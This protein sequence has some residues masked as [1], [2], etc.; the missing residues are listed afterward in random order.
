MGMAC[1]M[2][3]GVVLADV[4][5]AEPRNGPR[6][7]L[8]K[9]IRDGLVAS[10]A[11]MAGGNCGTPANFASIPFSDSDTTTGAT[12]IISTLPA[13]CSDWTQVAG[14]QKVYSFTAG[15]G[16]NLSFTVTPSNQSYDTSIYLVSSCSSGA[17]CIAGADYYYNYYDPGH[18]E[19][20]S[21]SSLT[22]GTTYYLHVDS[23]YSSSG[24]GGAYSSGPYALSV[25]GTLPVQLQEFQID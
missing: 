19:S 7:Q 10:P 9:Q 3:L 1:V 17:S 12:D 13:G 25:T 8:A 18:A 5:N 4:A 16:A 6:A 15:S 22:A 23:Y 11:P 21:V 2:A 14:P 20:F 24:K